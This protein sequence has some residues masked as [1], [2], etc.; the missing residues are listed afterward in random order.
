MIFNTTK[1]RQTIQTPF[2][3]TDSGCTSYLA[4]SK[5]CVPETDLSKITKELFQRYQNSKGEEYYK[6][7]YQLVLTAVSVVA[8]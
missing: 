5:L 6:V 2:R 3:D 7:S 4:V 1:T 8:V